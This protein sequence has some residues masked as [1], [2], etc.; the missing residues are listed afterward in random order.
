MN[1]RGQRRLSL[2]GVLG[3]V[4]SWAGRADEGIE[5]LEK[6]MRLSPHDPLM[7]L[8]FTGMSIA[9]F[10][11]ERYGEAA[12]WAQRSIRSGTTDTAAYRYIAASYAYLDRVDEA[13]K[14]LREMFLLDPK[15]SLAT[16]RVI[17]STADPAFVERLFDGLRKAGLKE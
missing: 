5:N 4:L 17:L 9:H 13:R 2:H 1:C 15:F 3:L 10:A 14:A 6:A 11:A 16:D 7:F 12:D 8:F